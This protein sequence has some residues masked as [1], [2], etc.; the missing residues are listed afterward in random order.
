MLRIICLFAIWIGWSS[1]Q[2]IRG[3]SIAPSI[4]SMM[5]V[6]KRIDN[7]KKVT[8]N[9][10][11]EKAERIH[12]NKIDFSK[13]VYVNAHTKVLL[14]CNLC[15]NEWQATPNS[16]LGG[17]GCP[18]CYRIKPLYGVG[19][20]DVC[21]PTRVG[22]VRDRAYQHWKSL[23]ERCYSDK[24]HSRQSSYIDCEVCDEWKYFSNFKKWFEKNYVDGYQL[25]KDI[26]VKGNKIYSP[27]T[28]CFVPKDINAAFQF[29]R[30]NANNGITES[31]KGFVVT[32]NMYNKKVIVGTFSNIDDARDA[33]ISAKRDYAY[34]LADKHYVQGEI[35]RKIYNAILNYF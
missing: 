20:N 18:F 5:D 7:M 17:S 32:V 26:L 12:S 11:V 16:I 2:P 14:K 25:D 22:N 27:N 19:I 10:F 6:I 31:K 1:Y 29:A 4:F 35:S 30:I 15:G 3:K 28:C 8:T 13:V 33:Y 34:E 9:E 21:L 23:I 24:Y